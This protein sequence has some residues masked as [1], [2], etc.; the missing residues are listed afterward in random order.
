VL[1]IDLGHR[2]GDT[3]LVGDA[4]GL[5]NDMSGIGIYPA[6]LSGQEVARQIIDPAY[7]APRLQA[8][9]RSKRMQRLSVRA[10]QC[11][12]WLAT[13]AYEL[14]SFLLSQIAVRKRFF[15]ST[16]GGH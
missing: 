2:F 6:C 3:F 13:Q 12:P 1:K 4:A 15:A 16:F 5:M 7:A 14:L 11:S 9:I 10:L 8:L